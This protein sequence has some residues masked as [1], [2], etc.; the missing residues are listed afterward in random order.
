MLYRKERKEDMQGVNAMAE[1][2]SYGSENANK[3]TEITWRFGLN[4]AQSEHPAW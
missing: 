4:S 1:K 2:L 3:L